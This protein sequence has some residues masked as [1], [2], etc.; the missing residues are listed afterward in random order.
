[1]KLTIA[2]VVISGGYLYA[3]W[4]AA[5]GLFRKPERLEAMPTSTSLVAAAIAVEGL[6]LKIGNG[7]SPQVYNAICNVQDL[8][9]PNVS[10]VVDITNVGDKYRRRI[11]TLLDLGKMKFKI[12]WVMTEP[13]HQNA[14][15]AGIQGLRYLWINQLLT[16][17]QFVYPNQNQSYDSFYAYVT[18]FTISGKVGGVFE[19][20]IELTAN[21]GNP[22]LA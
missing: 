7:A 10:E 18:S 22:Q 8:N 9:E 5:R 17:F 4:R 16:A 19:A 15:N 21:D 2:L 3:A 6:V 20:E 14:V 13:T 1:M 12:F 11:A